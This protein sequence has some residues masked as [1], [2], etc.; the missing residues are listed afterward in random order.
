MK[1]ILMILVLPLLATYNHGQQALF[2]DQGKRTS[3]SDQEKADL[4]FLREEEKL[5]HDVYVYSN[6]KYN[7][8]IFYNISGSEQ[9]HTTSVLGILTQYGIDDPVTNNNIGIFTNSDL[10]NLYNALSAKSDS[11]LTKAFEVC[12][13]IVDLDLNDIKTFRSHTTNEDLLSLYDRLACGSRNHLRS[14]VMQ[15]G[16]YTPSHVSQIEYSAIINGSH[17]P[18]GKHYGKGRGNTHR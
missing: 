10:Q 12:A 18:C 6:Q 14:F 13:V 2:Y 8:N 16:T 9:N 3:L 17:E 15:L 5:A 7:R 4:I 11:S 1:N